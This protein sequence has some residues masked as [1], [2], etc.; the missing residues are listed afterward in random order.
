MTTKTLEFW[1]PIISKLD[2]H[3]ALLI[4]NYVAK[5]T[6][7][8]APAFMGFW[9]C[10]TIRRW[11]I[12][13]MSVAHMSVTYTESSNFP[14]IATTMTRAEGPKEKQRHFKYMLLKTIKLLVRVLAL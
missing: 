10:N 13:H 5:L 9:A 4:I 12:L 1:N 6:N 8:S 11:K 3:V 7:N 14:S 2:K